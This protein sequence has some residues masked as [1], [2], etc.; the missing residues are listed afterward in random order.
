M[1]IISGTARGRRLAEFPGDKIR[2]TPD[3]VREALFS[4]LTSRLG[5]FAGLK[6]LDLCAGSGALSLEAI[7]R[8]AES[9]ILVDSGSDA[10]TLIEENIKRCK[11]EQKMRV[12]RQDVRRALPSLTASGPFDVIFMDPP[13]K[14]GLVPKFISEIERLNLISEDGIICAETETG[15]TVSDSGRLECFESRRYGSTTVH[16]LRNRQ[17]TEE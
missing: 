5:S 16:L 8:H 17:L 15:E 2:P 1:R 9:A 3:R 13:Y 11:F 7:S 14:L 12:I 10:I 6:V 4:L